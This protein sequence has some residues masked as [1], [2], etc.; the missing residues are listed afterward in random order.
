VSRRSFPPS[1]GRATRSRRATPAPLRVGPARVGRRRL[2]ERGNPTV[3]TVFE[4]PAR[5]V[6]KPPLRGKFSIGNP[7]ARPGPRPTPRRPGSGGG[8]G[9]GRASGRDPPSGPGPTVDGRGPGADAR[10]GRRIQAPNP[11]GIHRRCIMGLQI[12]KGLS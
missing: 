2:P 12:C 5:A 4:S 9:P 1:V 7:P 6:E 3:E 10:D 8:S 11:A